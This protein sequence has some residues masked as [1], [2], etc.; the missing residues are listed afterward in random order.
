MLAQLQ[1]QLERIYE[2]EVPHSVDDFLFTDP[3]ILKTLQGKDE[4]DESI[5]V[6]RLFVVPDGDPVDVVL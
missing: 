1:R 3:Q 4:C 6:G 5:V 2:I